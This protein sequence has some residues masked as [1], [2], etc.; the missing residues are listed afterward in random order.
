MIIRQRLPIQ[1]VAA[2]SSNDGFPTLR[3]VSMLVMIDSAKSPL[4]EFTPL[5]D[6]PMEAWVRTYL[7]NKDLRRALSFEP[8]PFN[9]AQYLLDVFTGM[10]PDVYS[11]SVGFD[12]GSTYEATVDA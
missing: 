1:C 12:G 4:G 10:D 11:V 7:A 2:I 3:P 9:L 8:T 6:E 5:T